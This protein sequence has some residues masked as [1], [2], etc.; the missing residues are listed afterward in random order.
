MIA[1]AREETVSF[2]A[3]QSSE[4]RPR[5]RTGLRQSLSLRLAPRAA[6]G[7]RAAPILHRLL[8]S[9]SC[10]APIWLGVGEELIPA[11]G[12]PWLCR[13]VG[14][15]GAGGKWF[16]LGAMAVQGLWSLNSCRGPAAAE[17]GGAAAAAAG[18]CQ[19]VSGDVTGGAGATPAAPSPGPLHPQEIL[20]QRGP[21]PRG[22][23][24]ESPLR[25]HPRVRAGPR[26]Y[27]L[28]AAAAGAVGAE[29]PAVGAGCVLSLGAVGQ[30]ALTP[31]GAAGA[32]CCA[33]PRH[34][35]AGHRAAGAGRRA[36]GQ[37]V[38]PWGRMSCRGGRVLCRGAGC[39]VVG[40]DVMPWGRTPCHPH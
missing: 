1:K 19:Q 24:A 22:A 2:L 11:P 23:G 12:L 40:Q 15:A 5:G 21:H 31:L 3:G 38:V 17:N 8:G 10:P 16:W 9:R 20:R 34:R 29:D 4:G 27:A 32:G 13:G 25:R 37:D 7:P 26:E 39:C 18:G 30:E 28:E 36:V 14:C 35:G 6:A 33:V